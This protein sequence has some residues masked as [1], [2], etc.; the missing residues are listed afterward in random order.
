MP[1]K[2]IIH[3][4][5]TYIITLFLRKVSQDSTARPERNDKNIRVG[6]VV[7]GAEV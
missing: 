6:T 7:P 5:I 2:W 1:I 4:S 3:Y